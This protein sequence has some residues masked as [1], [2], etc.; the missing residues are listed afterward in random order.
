MH[1]QRIDSRS[2]FRGTE[3]RRR[4][5]RGLLTGALAL[6]L[7]VHTGAGVLH[8]ATATPTLRP[9][10]GIW[11][12]KTEIMARPT[13]GTAWNAL[14]KAANATCATPDLS[15]QDDKANVCVLAKAL[16]FA[17]TGNTSYRNG[18]LSAL[19]SI[20]NSG[21]YSG[22]AL[23]LGRELYAYVISA[24]LIDL[25][26]VDPSTD[27]KFRTKIKSLL[28]TKTSSGPTSLIDC[29]ERRPNN[30]GMHCGAARAAVSAYLGDAA[31]LARTATVFKGWLGDRSAYA[32]FKWGELWW[33]C[34]S[35][36]PVGIN[37]K[38]CPM[39][40]LNGVLPDDQRRGG[41]Y[42]WPPEKE[43]YVWG[44]LAGASAQANI[45][46]RAGYDVWN[47]ED[48]ALLRAITWLHKEAN[49]PAEGDDTWQPHLFNYVY[50]TNFPAPVPSRPGKGIGYTDWTH[51]K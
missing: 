15:D 8:A 3:H 9:Q 17:R 25:K 28:T 2:A 18:V 4:G 23:A 27:S 14:L 48:K 37:R 35:S 36:K 22:R 16:V 10:Q 32:G 7:L 21:T 24:D 6:G 19:K 51:G 40:N 29:D 47:W 33:Q 46:Y 5:L 49:F 44:A 34:D 31:G 1:V 30:W 41:A 13:S 20:A 43:P 38:D 42:A 39:E 26:N 50:G 12:S 11:I 45:L